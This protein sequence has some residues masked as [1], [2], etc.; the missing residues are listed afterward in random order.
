MGKVTQNSKSKTFRNKFFISFFFRG[1]VRLSWALSPFQQIGPSSCLSLTI[2]GCNRASP[3]LSARSTYTFVLPNQ[4]HS[5]IR[6]S[7]PGFVVS[8][9][10][11]HKCMGQKMVSWTVSSKVLFC[12]FFSL[13][14]VFLLVLWMAIPSTIL[15]LMLPE[16]FQWKWCFCHFGCRFWFCLNQTDAEETP[17][18]L[19]ECFFHMTS[20]NPFYKVIP[21]M[22]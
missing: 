8:F 7:R 1:K 18:N 4:I 11:L 9:F 15:S 2:S 5:T 10:P 6:D 14:W 17:S 20:A 16:M 13:W 3:L 19:R 22:L 12:F 21:C